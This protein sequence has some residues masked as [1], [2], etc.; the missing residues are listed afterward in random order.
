MRDVSFDEETEKTTIL[1]EHKYFDG[2]T[3]LHLHIVSIF[4]AGDFKV[5]LLSKIS[6]EEI[7]VLS[8]IGVYGTVKEG[9]E[10]VPLLNAEYIR[11]WDWG[12]FSFMDYGKDKST[13]KWK[14]LRKVKSEDVYD[15][16]P[17]KDFYE[18]RLGKR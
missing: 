3:D 6:S 15:P 17:S 1:V 5:V 7:P 13:P 10:S 2:L 4:G 9:V 12:L 18:A 16:R 11:V 14:E 8:L